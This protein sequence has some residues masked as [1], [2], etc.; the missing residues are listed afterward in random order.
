MSAQSTSIT[1]LPT[2]NTTTSSGDNQVQLQIQEQSNVVMGQN[3]QTTSS[4]SGQSPAVNGTA[5]INLSKN[6]IN[7]I[8]EGIQL[9]SSQNMTQLPSRDIPMDPQQHTN[10]ANIQPNHIPKQDKKVSFVEDFEQQQKD[11]FEQ[12]KK[13]QNL[14]NQTSDIFESFQIPILIS[15]LFLLFQM[16]I[17]DKVLYR[18]FP[19]FFLKEGSIAIS[20]IL[21]KSFLFGS[22]FTLLQRL[23]H[24]LTDM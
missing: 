23:I 19:S 13:I 21:V 22:S 1:E 17:L 5:P 10:D 7:K 24:F 15:I 12:N 11:Y 18:N 4:G 2:A 9:A 3:G 14:E 20:G 8:V 16:P 6:D